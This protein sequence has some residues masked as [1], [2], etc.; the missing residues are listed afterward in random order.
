MPD[1]ASYRVT[2]TQSEGLVPRHALTV[3]SAM[4]SS[5]SIA[6]TFAA[7][8]LLGWSAGP[9]EAGLIV[10]GDAS[11][12]AVGSTQVQPMPGAVYFDQSIGGQSGF[13]DEGFSIGQTSMSATGGA[14]SSVDLAH[15]VFDVSFSVDAA[16]HF[17]LS[18]SVSGNLPGVVTLSTAF[19]S[20]SSGAMHQF[21][22]SLALA[23][24]L[25]PDKQYRLYVAVDP[26]VTWAANWSFNLTLPEPSA[27]G[28]LLLALPALALL[29][30]RLAAPRA[31]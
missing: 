12:I 10:L 9:A 18:G 4:A 17:T 7:A 26:P 24:V 31:R 28:L 6:A 13:A 15:S 21:D 23:G 8:I 29:R 19:L 30:L 11:Y 25:T 2:L 16:R 3:A 1:G 20:D 27:A 14:T 5:R 22:V